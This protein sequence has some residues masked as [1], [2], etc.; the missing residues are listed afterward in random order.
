MKRE[1]LEFLCCSNCH[2]DFQ[3]EVDDEKQDRIKSGALICNNCKKKIAIRNYIPRFIETQSY[4]DSFGSEWNAF[5]RVQL[6]SGQ[7]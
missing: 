7:I 1:Y 2:S 3:L 6:D 4:A 5:P